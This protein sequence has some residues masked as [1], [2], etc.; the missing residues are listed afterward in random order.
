MTL[1]IM[2]S[3]GEPKVPASL[4]ERPTWVLELGRYGRASYEWRR[5][6]A[7]DQLE[8]MEDPRG[9]FSTVEAEVS[10]QV[11]A[12]LEAWQALADGE[13]LNQIP[14][15]F[16]ETNQE[17]AAIRAI[18][19][20]PCKELVLLPAP[21]SLGAPLLG[22]TSLDPA[23]MTLLEA[24]SYETRPALG[25]LEELGHRLEDQLTSLDLHPA[26][27]DF[28]PTAFLP[29]ELIVIQSQVTATTDLYVTFN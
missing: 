27:I 10:R 11:R 13:E 1:E 25:D 22:E 12:D 8:M 6:V 16:A 20:R 2:M 18:E 28:T 23:T 7:L 24:T 4:Y 19:L 3:N 26:E 21:E 14:A 29:T 17:L 5:R 9:F 15:E